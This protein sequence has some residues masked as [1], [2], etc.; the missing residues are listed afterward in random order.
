MAVP[1]E[2]ATG[3]A[4]GAARVPVFADN[5]SGEDVLHG[6]N[7]CACGPNCPCKPLPMVVYSCPSSP[8]TA[9]QLGQTTAPPLYYPQQSY[10]PAYAPAYAPAYSQPFYMPSTGFSSCPTGTCPLR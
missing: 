8:A 2:A 3:P 7:D 4:A 10:T 5:A 1:A 9:A 6:A